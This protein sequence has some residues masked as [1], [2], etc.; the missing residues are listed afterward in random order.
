MIGSY[1]IR[2]GDCREAMACRPEQHFH[3]CVTSPPYF[4]LRD[5]NVAG[6]IGLEPTPDDFVNAMREVFGGKDNPVGVWRVLRDD[7]VLWL[8]LGDSYNSS[9]GS[10]GK[11]AKQCSSP[12]SLHSGGVRKC[13]GLKPKDLIGIPWR[14]AF[15]LQADGWYLRDAIIWHKPA[16]M[17]GSQ[18]DR[19]TSAYEFI[20]QLTK[21]PRYFFDI[22]AVKEK[23]AGALRGART[24]GKVEQFGTLRKDIGNQFE[25]I[26]TRAPRNVWKIAHEGF[27]DAHFATFPTEL[28]LRCI[29][30]S[31]SEKGCCPSCG[32]PWERILDR[33]RARTAGWEPGCDCHAHEPVPCRVL[34]PFNGAGTTGVAATSI[35][36]DYT[37]I[38]LNPEYAAMA[39]RRLAKALRGDTFRDMTKTDDAPLFRLR[40]A[41]ES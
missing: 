27:N 8:N 37:G 23:Q 9:S 17:P 6:Q 40:G 14:V 11:S 3:C 29:K 1:D 21:S 38:E 22:E 34:D 35:D 10:G 7:G 24:F 19:C 13:E 20:F 4:G 31:T 26:G 5:Y 12:G 25:D 18:R 36:R 15:A 30:A 41:D 2:V 28:P 33:D 16:P 39:D 32:A